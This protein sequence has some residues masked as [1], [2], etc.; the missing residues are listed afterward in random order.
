MS[1]SIARLAEPASDAGN[2]PRLPA[3][4][5]PDVAAFLEAKRTRAAADKSATALKKVLVALM[6]ESPTAFCGR[7][8]MRTKHVAGTEM[9]ITLKDGRVISLAAIRCFKLTSGET[10]G[11]DKIASLVGARS[12][13][14]D[15][16]ID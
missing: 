10:I 5:G 1:L 12:G 15:L 14:V 6:G 3:E 7:Y 2:Y 4:Y 16:D 13:Y 8:V 9:R 11:P